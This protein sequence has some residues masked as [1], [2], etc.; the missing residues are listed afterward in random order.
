MLSA[1]KLEGAALRA[2]VMPPSI[3]GARAAGGWSVLAR[4]VGLRLLFLIRR[5]RAFLARDFTMLVSYRMDFFMRVLQT[6]IIVISL[7]F[8]SHVF[9][10]Q[11][12]VGNK[13]WNDPF[14]AWIIGFALMSYFGCGFSSLVNAIRSEQ[15]QGTLENVIMSPIKVPTMI[16]ASTAFEFVQ[17]TFFAC[18]YLFLGWCFFGVRFQGNFFLALLILFLTAL[19]LHSI[20]ILSASFTLVFKRG[21]PFGAT[22]A[23]GSFLLSGVLFPT[24]ALNGA[25]HGISCALPTTYGLDGIR[26]VL[27]EGQSWSQ[28]RGTLGILSLF[29]IGLLP[30]SLVVFSGALRR[31]KREG[32]LIQ[33]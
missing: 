21:D 17:A 6:V 12:P 19:V 15:M 29:L 24:Q 20:G 9:R 16:I 13:Q 22:L 23:T 11:A 2:S 7:F 30:F 4:A 28:V 8:I 18:L 27:I 26:R 33:Y 32:S 3:Q 14:T 25:F 5:V 31:A 1:R 10:G